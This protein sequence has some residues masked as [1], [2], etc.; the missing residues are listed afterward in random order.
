MYEDL[1][2][3]V[4]QIL[5][6]FRCSR[7]A[8]CVQRLKLILFKIIFF[9]AQVFKFLLFHSMSFRT[10]DGK[11]LMAVHHH[12][13]INGKYHRD[14]RLFEVDLSGDKLVVGDFWSP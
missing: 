9:S 5:A 3:R 1:H 8:D 12:E 6:Q 7:K 4:F 10:F 2:V 14:A 11:M 13:V